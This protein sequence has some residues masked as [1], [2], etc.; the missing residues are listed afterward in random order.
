L[1]GKEGQEQGGIDIY[2][3]RKSTAKYAVW[4]SKRHESFTPSKLN[5]AVTDFMDGEW[6]GKTDLFVICVKASLRSPKTV[7]T[8]EECAAKLRGRG[9]EFQTMD[10]EELSRKL[11]AL[12]EIVDD[13][14]G[15]A[16]VERFCEKDAAKDLQH[17]LR[18]K[19]LK[20]LRVSLRKCYSAHFATV[21]PGVLG[22]MPISTGGKARLQLLE[23]FVAPDLRLNSDNRP[24][25]EPQAQEPSSIDPALGMGAGTKPPVRSATQLQQEKART[26]LEN[27]IA[28]A[29]HDV[30]LGP[31]GTGKS[32]LLRFV[33]LDMLADNPTLAVLRRRL[34][35]FLPVWVSFAFW[36]KL[37]AADKE[38]R[39]LLDAVEAWFRRQD[40]PDLVDL[41][42]KALEDK[43]LILL[44]DGIDE[45]DNET[46]ANT[47]L[48]LLQSF[49]ERRSIP[50]I[51]TSAP[52][53]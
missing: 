6:A 16:W 38:P 43:R 20:R 31:A 45:W 13:F 50:V 28:D 46:A 21:D 7:T 18:P 52:R 19:E 22:Q 9:V 11:K 8:I 23:R 17:R 4:Q 15:R 29:R 44:V 32:T 3:R 53:H 39:S 2:V 47:A 35:D 14:F 49:A 25:E 1:Y 33:A 26:T 42:R 24:T 41:V 5:A 51:L 48:G 27:W 10:G 40:E 12:P 37:I 30:V 36:T 34:P